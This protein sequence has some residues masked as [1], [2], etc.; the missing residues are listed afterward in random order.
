MQESWLAEKKAKRGAATGNW[1]VAVAAVL[2][3]AVLAVA[4]YGALSHR[5]DARDAGEMVRAEVLWVTDGD[6]IFV[7]LE[8]GTENHVRLI[9]INSEEAGTEPGDAATAF[10]KSLLPPGC[11]VWLARDVSDTD[12]YGRW[13]RYVWLEPPADPSNPEEVRVKMVNG[14]LVAAGHAEAKRYPPDTAYS[15]I[16]EA[17]EADV[18]SGS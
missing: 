14:I 10:T 11:K 9:G 15:R 8:D 7:R 18:R 17:V 12:K 2:T 1:S 4:V 6:T 3:V 16:F 13:L 5:D